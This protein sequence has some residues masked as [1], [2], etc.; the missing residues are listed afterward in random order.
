MYSSRKP[1]DGGGTGTP[2]DSP[3]T[4]RELVPRAGRQV[5]ESR[6]RANPGPALGA[7]SP[8]VGDRPRARAVRLPGPPAE[9]E[10]RAAVP[11]A[12]PAVSCV[13]AGGQAR[14]LHTGQVPTLRVCVLVSAAQLCYI[15]EN[16]QNV[17]STAPD[18]TQRRELVGGGGRG[19]TALSGTRSEFA[20]GR[21]VSCDPGAQSWVSESRGRAYPGPALR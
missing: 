8:G 21:A 12:A 11:A 4:H 7:V 3:G 1:R 6:G 14:P 20:R 9:G 18:R 2:G 17:D 15:Y 5:G 13:W 16:H 19:V 10:A